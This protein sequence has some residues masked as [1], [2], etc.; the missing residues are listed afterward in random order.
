MDHDSPMRGVY[1]LLGQEVN[2]YIE[3]AAM[4]IS[5]NESDYKCL[6][7]F[8]YAMNDMEMTDFGQKMVQVVKDI[9]T[10]DTVSF[11]DPQTYPVVR[12]LYYDREEHL[13][14]DYMMRFKKFDHAYDYLRDNAF[15]LDYENII[16][17][18]DADRGFRERNSR[19][20]EFHQ[21]HEIS[22]ELSIIV[23]TFGT[24]IKVFRTNGDIFTER[25]KNIASYIGKIIQSKYH[26]IRENREMEKQLALFNKSIKSLTYGYMLISRD[27]KMIES[28]ELVLSY[29]YEITNTY[30][31]DSMLKAL[32][33]II[34]GNQEAIAKL[35]R[36]EAAEMTVGS[37]LVEVMPTVMVTANNSIETY[38]TIQIFSK[39]WLKKNTQMTNHNFEKYN[40][41][42]RESET[43][44]LLSKGL[45]NKEIAARLGISIYTVK[46]HMKNIS[47]KMNVSSRTAIVSKLAI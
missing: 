32:R 44:K 11:I 39:S 20:F 29:G 19:Y 42:T 21:R 36:N 38:F 28:N 7:R 25:E 23:C 46:E 24:Q 15:N 13:I 34:E 10:A 1:L 26:L 9:F 8:H 14:S 41:T 47:R 40:L 18:S 33:G 6:I 4:S 45:S 30:Y 17:L 35:S 31:V 27:Y 3:E 12:E 16:A 2:V 22:D 43:V 37:Y 5:L